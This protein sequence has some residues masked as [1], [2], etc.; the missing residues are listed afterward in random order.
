MT[1]I[2]APTAASVVVGALGLLFYL[3]FHAIAFSSAGILPNCCIGATALVER[4]PLLTAHRELRKSPAAQPSG[5]CTF[6]IISKFPAAPP[7]H[8][9]HTP[10]TALRTPRAIAF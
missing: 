4:I 6:F 2:L 8:D 1:H 3:R 7:A 10:Q 9:W 5:G